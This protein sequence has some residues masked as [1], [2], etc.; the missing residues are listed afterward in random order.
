MWV[1]SHIKNFFFLFF[2]FL[3]FFGCMN[4][5]HGLMFKNLPSFYCEKVI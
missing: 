5:G 3:T 2:K 4:V 1:M